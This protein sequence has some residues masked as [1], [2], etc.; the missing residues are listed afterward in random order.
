MSDVLK[1]WCW[2]HDLWEG[3]VCSCLVPGA[4]LVP[5]SQAG[6]L[7]ISMGVWWMQAP[8]MGLRCLPAPSRWCFWGWGGE[9]AV[10]GVTSSGDTAGWHCTAPNDANEMG[11]VLWVCYCHLVR[12]WPPNWCRHWGEA[13]LG[14]RNVLKCSTGAW[15][16][17]LAGTAASSVPGLS[18]FGAG[19]TVTAVLCGD[20]V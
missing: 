14:G 18:Q 3:S 12:A 16:T 19:R 6:L 17:H 8:F 10:V 1:G 20:P 15:C 11:L 2:K 4:C 5:R 7:G 13:V 9:E